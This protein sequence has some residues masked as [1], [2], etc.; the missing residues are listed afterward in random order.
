MYLN[1]ISHSYPIFQIFVDLFQHP[2]LNFMSFFVVAVANSPLNPI[3]TASMQKSKEQHPMEGGKHTTDHTSKK[4]TPHSLEAINFQDH[5]SYANLL[6][7]L[8]A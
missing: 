5:L 2:S 7:P 1:N 8:D 3:M 4:L 6:C